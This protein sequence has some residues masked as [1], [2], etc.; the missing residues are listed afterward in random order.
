[1]GFG[2]GEVKISARIKVPLHFPG[3][4]TS[5]PPAGDLK[6]AVLPTVLMEKISLFGGEIFVPWGEK[7]MKIV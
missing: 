2:P 4:V 5:S 3:H 7:E 1:V 6:I